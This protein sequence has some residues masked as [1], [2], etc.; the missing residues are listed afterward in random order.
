MPTFS[1]DLTSTLDIAF[2]FVG[3]LWAAYAIPLSITLG[4][5]V[6]ALIYTLLSKAFNVRGGSTDG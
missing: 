3:A 2:E 6:L 1:I 4:F 5:G